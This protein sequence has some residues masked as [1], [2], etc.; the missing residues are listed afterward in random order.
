[1]AAID[2]LYGAVTSGTHPISAL[3][4]TNPAPKAAAPKPVT[5][6]P[7]FTSV[8]APLKPAAS[9]PFSAYPAAAAAYTT[10]KQKQA[11]SGVSSFADP[12]AA[13]HAAVAAMSP[14]DL[15]NF[16]K[17]F[18]N[19][20]TGGFAAF[21]EKWAPIIIAGIASGG[22]GAGVGGAVASAGY[23][24]LAAGAAGGAAAGAAG[25]EIN[26]LENNLTLAKPGQVVKG[27]VTGAVGGGIA[28]QLG[29]VTHSLTNAGLPTPI[30][31]GLVKGAAGAVT[32]AVGGAI[33]GQGAGKG[34]V[35]GALQGAV[36][37]A[38]SAVAGSI[39]NSGN[40]VNTSNSTVI[41][42]P[43]NNTMADDLN[44][45]DTTGNYAQ[46]DPA[47]G[48]YTG[49]GSGSGGYYDPSD[50]VV[51]ANTQAGQQ[52]YS[53]GNPGGTVGNGSPAGGAGSLLATL[54]SKLFGSN[55]S[56]QNMSMLS[57]LL[58]FGANAGAGI[59]N[60]NAA[61]GAA[62][63]FAGQT[64]FNPYAVQSSAGNTTFNNGNATSTLSAGNQANLTGLNNL[65]QQS[66][67]GLK[68]GPQG[69][70]NQY[71]QQLQAQQK[72]GNDRFMANNADSEFGKGILAST[73]GQYQTQGAVDSIHNQNLQDSVLANNFGQ[74]Q[75]QAQLAQLTAG[76]NGA[77]NINQQQLQQIMYGG[78]LGSAA[79]S[80]NQG[81]YKPSL[82]ANSNSTFG[83]ILSALGNQNSGQYQ[84]PPGP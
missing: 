82:V 22:I 45:I 43:T 49:G 47:T 32:G 63:T 46:F 31:A 80:A 37:G 71:Y 84:P 39:F 70:A 41:P 68:A 53:S 57:S 7:S 25:T 73:A 6:I 16:Q 81:A 15:S 36:A 55:V 62:N 34:A 72:Q 51:Q 14:A 4:A 77:G 40:T 24:G 20:N 66:L 35:G 42:P 52:Y 58:G 59:L 21:E 65:S 60:S 76:L 79:S 13:E 69:A 17:E 3:Y 26:S 8:A 83:G 5:S 2:N 9:N 78:N 61:K 74:G 12:Y 75:Q 48:G 54:A 19:H 28:S 64:K 1:M 33:T 23:G 11:A 10:A 38:G 30:A 50:P 18:I 67:A 27:A 56:P 44:Y 29:G